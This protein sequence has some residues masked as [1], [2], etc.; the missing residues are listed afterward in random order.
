MPIAIWDK[1]RCHFERA[2]GRKRAQ[3]RGENLSNRPCV[4][5]V[6]GLN[7]NVESGMS[8]AEWRIRTGG[9]RIIFITLIFDRLWIVRFFNYRCFYSR[10]GASWIIVIFTEWSIRNWHSAFRN[11][12]DDPGNLK[13]LLEIR[14]LP[15]FAGRDHPVGFAGV[16]Y[17][18]LAAYRWGEIYL[19]SGTCS[20]PAR[21]MHRGFA[22]DCFDEGS[23]GK[24]K[25]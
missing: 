22:F 9:V 8:M 10:F 4:Y 5:P 3:G 13:A 19:L 24:S 15:A 25:N 11:K 14:C 21:G 7:G 1:K 23:S 20:Y 6:R 2:E 12:N 17:P 16:W 18:G